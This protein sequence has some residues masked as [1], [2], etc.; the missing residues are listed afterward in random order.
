M[1]EIAI[2]SFDVPAQMV[3]RGQ[4]G[5]RKQNGVQERGDQAASAKT[6]AINEEDP[7]EERGFVMGVLDLAE[8]IA[9]AESLQHLGTQGCLRGNE[10]VGMAK[11]D[12][13]ESGAGVETVVQE[14]Q[15][16]LLK[17]LNELANEFVFRSTYLIVDEAQGRAADQV[18][19]AAKLDRNGP[20]SLLALVGAETLPKRWRFGQSESGLVAGK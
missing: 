19:E 7:D 20:Q 13:A 8:I 6:V 18:K 17:V 1:L 10:E 4:F 5:S 15:I 2:E 11:E 14:K 9:R 3:E 12:L 16:T